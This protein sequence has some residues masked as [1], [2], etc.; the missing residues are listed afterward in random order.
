[1]LFSNLQIEPDELPQIEEVEFHSLEPDYLWMRL[2]GW[3]IFFLIAAGILVFVSFSASLA[4]WMLIAPLLVL[5]LLV[6]FIEVR[7]FKI[8]GY[9]LRENDI[10]YKSG[11]LFF[12]MTSI[13]LNRLQHCEVSQGPLGRLFELAS[14]RIYTAGGSTSDLSIGGLKKEAAHRLRDHITRLSARYE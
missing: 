4:L 13:P 6:T 14:V 7:G 1:M 12:S 2:T 9:A 5:A 11:L 8:K 3:G 10:S